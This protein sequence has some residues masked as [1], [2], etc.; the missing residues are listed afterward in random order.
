M[1]C[2][3]MTHLHT[4]VIQK[5]NARWTTEEQL[6]AVQGM[7]VLLAELGAGPDVGDTSRPAPSTAHAGTDPW[8]I[9]VL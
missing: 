8:R 1:W 6:L 2:P 7:G 5:C 3:D 4:Q 9:A